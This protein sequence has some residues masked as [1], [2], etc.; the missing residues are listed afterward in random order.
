MGVDEYSALHSGSSLWVVGAEGSCQ[1]FFLKC[2]VPWKKNVPIL[3]PKKKKKSANEKRIRV[4][5][6]GRRSRGV[7]VRDGWQRKEQR[8][9]PLCS[10]PRPTM[11][12]DASEKSCKHAPPSAF[13]RKTVWSHARATESQKK[14]P[15]G[16]NTAVSV[17]IHPAPD[18]LVI[19]NTHTQGSIQ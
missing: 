18:E 9:R 13:F 8:C 5:E 15:E 12:S 3:I 7:N 11:T 16:D 19:Y 1:L 10:A 17:F 4:V 14:T 2:L 6:R